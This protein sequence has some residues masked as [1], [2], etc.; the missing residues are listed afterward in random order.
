MQ[1]WC[2]YS[3]IHFFMLG[4]FF[5]DLFHS[6]LLL[7]DVGDVGSRWPLLVSRGWRENC[8]A[9]GFLSD[10]SAAYCRLRVNAPIS[11]CPKRAQQRTLRAATQGTCSFAIFGTMCGHSILVSRPTATEPAARIRILREHT[12]SA[13]CKRVRQGRRGFRS[14]DP[15]GH[16]PS[17]GTSS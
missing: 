14:A 5:A 16:A 6:A 7:R 4:C 2:I 10:M 9:F 1:P 8:M 12:F 15:F 11:T 3:F 17:N 13:G